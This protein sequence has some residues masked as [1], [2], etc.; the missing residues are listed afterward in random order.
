MMIGKNLCNDRS[1][2][3][4][5]AT[6]NNFGSRREGKNSCPLYRCGQKD[7]PWVEIVIASSGTWK[8]RVLIGA[9]LAIST[10]WSTNDKNYLMKEEALLVFAFPYILMID[11]KIRCR[12]YKLTLK[13]TGLNCHQATTQSES[14]MWWLFIIRL[15]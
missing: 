1:I 8:V 6:I 15:D 3:W 10:L 9:H 4:L 2:G 14:N 12:A 5:V 11:D 7:S 13:R